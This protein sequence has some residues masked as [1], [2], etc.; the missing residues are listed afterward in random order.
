MR[1]RA[2]L[3]DGWTA[4]RRDIT[5]ARQPSAQHQV[6]NIVD[7]RGRMAFCPGVAERDR[8]IIPSPLGVCLSL[9]AALHR[10]KAAAT[11]AGG[12]FSLNLLCQT[13]ACRCLAWR[14]VHAP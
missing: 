3:Y 8:L 14:R 4:G 5:T 10:T 13:H 11:A 6:T 9:W 1:Q 12:V 2:A 7:G